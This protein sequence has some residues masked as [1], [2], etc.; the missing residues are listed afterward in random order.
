M[1][2]DELELKGSK[3]RDT[4][5][6]INTFGI[7]KTKSCVSFAKASSV[8]S[9]S[10]PFAHNDRSENEKN[11]IIGSDDKQRNEFDQHALDAEKFYKELRAEAEINYR[12][13]VGQKMQIKKGNDHWEAVINLKRNHTILDVQKVAQYLEKETGFTAVQISV[14]KDEGHFMI[15]GKKH[16][17]SETIH[18]DKKGKWFFD[19]AFKEPVDMSKAKKIYNNH[20]HINF[21]TL[22]RKTGIQLYHR[23]GKYN[24][25]TKVLTSKG[26]TKKV[27]SEIQTRT[28]EILGMERGKIGSKAVRLTPRQYRAVEAEKETVKQRHKEQIKTLGNEYKEA[29]E[30]LKKSGS[31]TQKD[32]QELKQKHEH[33]KSEVN[34]DKPKKK[35]LIDK[36]IEKVQR[37]RHER[38]R[39]NHF[40]N[41]EKE[42]LNAEKGYREAKELS[43]RYENEDR[44]F[45]DNEPTLEHCE[46]LRAL[47][48]TEEKGKERKEQQK[49]Q[50]SKLRKLQL[51][52]KQRKRTLENYL[53]PNSKSL[54]L[55][56]RRIKTRSK[57]TRGRM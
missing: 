28:A 40:L 10:S 37:I 4:E 15:D 23:Y 27:L 48:S 25:R 19:R 51:E 16:S 55:A 44:A 39:N 49:Q 14:H 13:K 7:D 57:S 22:Q 35:S 1:L 21:F 20:A 12:K 5:I 33:L 43:E 18:K 29:R 34:T 11:Y 36:G 42:Y 50:Q 38:E 46:T 2:K 26:M 6:V 24:K 54:A 3:A 41:A 52:L 17:P 53:K 47:I 31:A 30:T 45:K 32:Y 8:K 56:K 9:G